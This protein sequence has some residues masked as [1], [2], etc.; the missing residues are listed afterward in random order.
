VE[1]CSGIEGKCI[2]T[3]R[4]TA[5]SCTI[6]PST[7]RRQVQPAVSTSPGEEIVKAAEK[8]HCDVILHGIART[9]GFEQI[10]RRQ[11][12]QKVLA[13]TNLPVLVIR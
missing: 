3:S 13:S 12:N 6:T 5:I 11:R 8:F 10:V 1:A 2:L 4:A 7:R 9:Q